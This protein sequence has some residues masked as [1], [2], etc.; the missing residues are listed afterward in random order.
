MLEDGQEPE[1]YGSRIR[2]LPG[3]RQCS[4]VVVHPSGGESQYGSDR[5][6]HGPAICLQTCTD[7]VTH[8]H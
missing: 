1:S 7:Q 4:A 6:R 2:G 8:N 5:L 3:S